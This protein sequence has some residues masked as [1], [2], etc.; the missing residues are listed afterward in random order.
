MTYLLDTNLLVYP[1]DVRDEAKQARARFLIERLALDDTASLSS[2]ALAEFSNV[3]L[4]KLRLTPT[5]M[6]RQVEC[7]TQL[8][9]VIPLTPAVVLEAVRGVGEHTMSYYDA[10]VWAAAKLNQVPVVLSEDFPN[11]ATVE[12][13]TFLNPLEADF[14]LGELS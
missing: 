11:G 6:I 13:V 5:F 3:G 4:K 9:Q 1:Y 7:Y 10:Q 12:G 2:Q 14:D 8:F